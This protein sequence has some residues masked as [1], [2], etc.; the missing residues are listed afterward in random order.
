[1][2]R[3]R[4]WG[5]AFCLC[6]GEDLLHAAAAAHSV[7]ETVFDPLREVGQPGEL[8][9][10]LP[11]QYPQNRRI[12][13]LGVRGMSG[14]QLG[15]V[16]LRCLLWNIGGDFL[17]LGKGT[18]PGGTGKALCGLLGIMLHKGPPHCHRVY[19]TPQLTQCPE[20]F[21]RQ[22]VIG[23]G[24]QPAKPPAPLHGP[25]HCLRIGRAGLQLQDQ[26]L[27]ELWG[28]QHCCPPVP[29]GQCPRIHCRS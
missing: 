24:S 4:A 7:P 15:T 11:A 16:K 9:S 18:Q 3:R 27:P 17:R 13:A 22:G 28:V 19:L 20:I 25:A 1:M 14:L 2:R 8:L 10:L 6:Q 26:G 5:I 21:Q 29:A 12:Q 23:R